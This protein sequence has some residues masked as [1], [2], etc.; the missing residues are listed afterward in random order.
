MPPRP[1]RLSIRYPASS[2]PMRGSAATARFYH[3][4][5][6][7][8]SDPVPGRILAAVTPEPLAGDLVGPYR[9]EAVLG[10]G[11]V[12]VVYL[13]RPDGG[14][15]AVALK[16]LR[17]DLSRDEIFVRRFAHEARAAAEVRDRH[18]VPILDTGEDAGRAWLA[19]AYVA[20]RTLAE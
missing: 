9:V 19:M 2:V 10:E 5:G 14:G 1:S 13:A 7:G 17:A 11:A 16:V 15:D 8:G 3:R 4:G 6:A 12:G 20:G 18:L